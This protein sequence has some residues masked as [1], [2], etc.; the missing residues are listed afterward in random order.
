MS[1]EE[2]REL[3]DGSGNPVNQQDPHLVEIETEAIE[4][5]P[6]VDFDNDTSR[7]QEAVDYTHPAYTPP[8]T[9]GKRWI[10]IQ[11]H[12]HLALN[13]WNDWQNSEN[14]LVITTVTR[15][16]NG[17][18]WDEVISVE[19][20]TP[21]VASQWQ[22][23]VPNSSQHLTTTT[24]GYNIIL[25]YDNN[26]FNVGAGQYNIPNN[27]GYFEVD[28][29]VT[30]SSG[31]VEYFTN[32]NFQN[33]NG[34]VSVP[35]GVK[36]DN[37]LD[38]GYSMGGS[39]YATKQQAT[40]KCVSSSNPN[41]ENYS[42]STNYIVSP[43]TISDYSLVTRYKPV[44][45]P[46]GNLAEV[47]MYKEYLA[48]SGIDPFMEPLVGIYNSYEDPIA[49]F[50]SNWGL[51]TPDQ[52]TSAK[53][54]FKRVDVMFQHNNVNNFETVNGKDRA[55]FQAN[56]TAGN[57]GDD[58][59]D[60]TQTSSDPTS[61]DSIMYAIEYVNQ[62]Q[63]LFT[64]TYYYSENIPSCI[65]DSPSTTYHVCDTAG[66]P[67]YYLTTGLDC[68]GATI[69][70]ADLPGG[71]NYANVTYIH[72]DGC[73]T[74][75][76]LTLS[77]SSINA[78]YGASDGTIT[79]NAADASGVGTGTPYSSGSQYTVTIKDS[80][81]T[82]VGTQ[83]PTGGNT[84]TDA[85]CDTNTTAATAHLVTCDSSVII[86]PGMQVSGT[87]IPAN[88]F[89]GEITAGVVSTNVTQFSLVD[90]PLYP[91]L[92]NLVSATAVNTN[93]TLTFSAGP[94][95]THG[96]LPASTAADPYYTVCVTDSQSC[97]ECATIDVK[98]TST[99]PSGCTDNTAV[100]YDASAVTDDGSCIL[101]QAA[102]GLLHD[103]SGPNTTDMFDVPSTSSTPATWNSGWTTST[104]HN[105]DGVLSVSVAPISAVIS[106]ITWDVN[107]KFELLLYKTLNQGEPSTASGAVQIGSTIN[108]GT[109]NTVSVA[110]HTWTGLAHGY[111]TVRVRYVDDNT[112]STLE[113][114]WTEFHELVQAEVCDDIVSQAYNSYPTEVPLRFSNPNLC[115]YSY[116]CCNLLDI[117]EN[118]YSAGT[119]CA[120]V[121]D[122]SV[123]C[124][125]QRTVDVE[126]FYSSNG[127]SYASLGA[128]SLGLINNYTEI[129]ANA[130]NNP[131]GGTNWYTQTGYYKVVITCTYS[132]TQTP[133]ICV[134]EKVGLFT[135]PVYG[136]TDATAHNYDPLAVCQTTCAYPSWECDSGTG[137]CYDPWTGTL[138][139]YTPGPYSCLNGTGCCNN[140]C[141][142]PVIYGCTDS[143]AT[144]YDANATNDDGSCTY[145]ACLD[146]AATNYQQNCC[147]N[148]VYSSA[149]IVG[150]DN[151]C[152]I[153]PCNTQNNI[154]TTTTD[155]TSTC[156]TFNTDGSVNVSLVVNNSAA[157]WTWKIWDNTYTTVV[158]TDT[159]GGPASDGVYNGS[160][161]SDTYS[162]LS[163]GTYYAEITDSFGCHW[164]LVF[165]IGSTSPLV[166]CTDPN[167][168][169][170]QP[171]AVCDCCCEVQGCLDP[172]AGNYNPNANVPGECDY[173][174]PPPSPCI[175]ETLEKDKVTVK[176]CLSL[177]GSE[178]L[179]DYKIG[180]ADECTI[181][182]KWKLI[183]IDYL[184]QQDGLSCLF[185]CA[186]IQ[187]PDPT[188]AVDCNDLW[189]TGG[190]STGLNHDPNHA[191]ASV[192]AGE[193][194][195]VT[196]YD[197]FP[198]GWFGRDTT[199]NPSNNFT[200]VGDVVKWDLPSGHPMDYLN[201]T[202][203]TLT[204]IPQNPQ[205]AH[206][207][208]S[209]NGKITH[210]TQCLDYNTISI[211]TTTNYY[212]KFLN[213][214]NKFCA[215]CDIS[216]LNG[217]GTKGGQT[218]QS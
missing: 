162:S 19:A 37:Q 57:N 154:T 155:T 213:F 88:T 179:K 15:P 96:A 8:P 160:T 203:W 185:N 135:L 218:A 184:L 202:I 141:T 144:N 95:G 139:G 196:G 43:S 42:K 2:T 76:Q 180:M 187:T 136:C 115:S 128:Y 158:Y 58:W 35:V 25:T 197:N 80:A 159:T 138:N 71:G 169:N 5:N 74:S 190:P 22:G 24:S 148:N 14:G 28:L 82:V 120:P 73:C 13:D 34:P 121:L 36:Y 109:L 81:G 151:S 20:I 91:T 193:G 114:C 188:A 56:Y 152:C 99:P 66:N 168:D 186:D 59:Y 98:G 21:Y 167:A 143:C 216:I 85:T 122:S 78:S 183:L 145:T 157:T 173:P 134:V 33:D 94:V 132:G 17:S 7:A 161:T 11:A 54:V 111:Y 65:P 172:N 79:W 198:N 217:R 214:V 87:G 68:N 110:A 175:P 86:K 164:S 201:G 104:V 181:M 47:G 44:V 51:T 189:I 49:T 9:S 108:A 171:D 61:F 16:D 117:G 102:D 4:D 39:N 97:R 156:T 124:D 23:Q 204:L 12:S 10:S 106:Y 206:F 200:F 103:P 93:V 45:N 192:T 90:N 70:A 123:A 89:V 163:L 29:K 178:W 75:C 105:T 130:G 48:S 209:P 92:G 83:L 176:T 147:N 64:F 129:Y 150:P 170:Y 27:N 165:T 30:F 107:S 208:C 127:A 53:Q 211:T 60:D 215:D 55:W 149:Q 31:H 166:G 126:W 146:Q 142:P 195:T 137:T 207:G 191:A 77:L 210:Y 140:Y 194:T 205:G 38:H 18:A 84:V 118:T 32:Q 6:L 212:D 63:Y 112:T 131:F 69:P 26:A 133:D 113:N 125:P 50:Y 153:N 101:C 41:E 67:S 182:N 72:N 62:E 119:Q 1:E 40:L 199:L 174:D 3:V 52:L 46:S 177:E 100:N 116:P